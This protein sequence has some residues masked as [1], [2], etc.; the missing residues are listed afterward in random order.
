MIRESMKTLS[1]PAANAPR[2]IQN[3]SL[4]HFG[5]TA[6]GPLHTIVTDPDGNIYYSDEI[7]H[8]VVSLKSDGSVRWHR[9][10]RGAA[11]GEFWY[12][13]GL[14]LG[15]L[16]LHG[17]TIRCLAVA[18]AWNRRVQFLDVEGNPLTIWTHGGKQPFGEVADARF[19][20]GNM[21]PKAGMA[22][23]G[24]WYVLDR[25]NHRLCKL[26]ME[27]SILDQI[28]RCLPKSMEKRWA[29]PEIFFGKA[30]KDGK[31]FADVS[32]LDFTFFPNRILG[33][34]ADSLFVCE[35]NSRELKQIIPPHLIPVCIDNDDNLEWIAADSSGLLGWDRVGNQLMR[36]SGPHSEYEQVEIIGEP[37]PSN[38]P[39]DEF[40]MQAEDS[41]GMCKWPIAADRLEGGHSEFYPWF[42]QSGEKGLDL[43]D[44]PAVQKAVEACLTYVDEEIKLAD[45]ILAMGEKDVSQGFVDGMSG[46]IPVFPNK[47][48]LFL[49]GVHEILHN[50][51]LDQLGRHLAG[52]LE[53]KLPEHSANPRQMQEGLAIQIGIRLADIQKR[54]RDLNDRLSSQTTSAGAD[55]ITPDPWTKVALISR[56]HLEFAQEWLANWSGVSIP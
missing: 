50:W 55:A 19:I 23:V 3:L 44:P 16:Q 52:A 56:S 18:D 36:R 1:V 33:N 45:T 39:S 32:P 40:W 8:S 5:E 25:G 12:P 14:S 28:G 17:E 30:S 22:P 27:G 43:L 37:V 47:C 34:T 38:R 54:K 49:Q 15:C 21:N 51:C 31:T 29:A 53:I 2:I 4:P 35:S 13:R 42:I 20:P 26:D 11:L 7:N 46:H 24:F 10:R 6:P 41:I 9:T 48:A